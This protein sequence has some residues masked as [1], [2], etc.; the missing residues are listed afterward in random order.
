MKR[1]VHVATDGK[2][3]KCKI[4]PNFSVINFSF[5]MSSFNLKA[6]SFLASVR[7]FVCMT[8]RIGLGVPYKIITARLGLSVRIFQIH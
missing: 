5:H 7:L 3:K 2:A 6:L 8:L 4:G 1:S